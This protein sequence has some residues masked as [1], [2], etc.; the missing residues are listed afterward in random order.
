[1]SITI[2][3]HPHP[4]LSP[5]TSHP[6]I[7]PSQ[8]TLTCTLTRTPTRTRTQVR[9]ELCSVITKGTAFHREEQATY[10]L[11]VS[12]DIPTSTLGVTFVDAATGHFHVGQCVDDTQHSCLR[13]LLAQV[14]PYPQPSPSPFTLH[15]LTSPSPLTLAS[16]LSPLASHLSPLTSH[17]LPLTLHPFTLPSHTARVAPP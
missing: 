15:L 10:L 3:L 14:S 17:L 5:L 11:A 7:S 2:I 6:H 12:E 8:L 9:R 16:H 1:M 4:H 13:T